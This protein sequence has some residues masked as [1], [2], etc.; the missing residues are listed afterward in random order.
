VWHGGAHDEAALAGKLRD[1]L[2][3]T[4]GKVRSTVELAESAGA[5]NPRR[6]K[7]PLARAAKLVK[8]VGKKIGGR[9]GV[10]AIPDAAARA[11]LQS[12]VDALRAAIL[13]LRG[14]L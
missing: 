13:A 1:G 3:A 2:I 14:L 9:K 7:K 8:K 6:A 4:L 12:D 5:S 11:A 10:A